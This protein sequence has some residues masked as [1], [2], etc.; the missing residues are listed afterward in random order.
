MGNLVSV[1]GLS[2]AGSRVFQ[3]LEADNEEDAARVGSPAS[4][5]I[6]PSFALQ[7]P[8]HFVA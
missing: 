7:L 6:W 1:L 8:Q 5:R 2:D 3:Y 4:G